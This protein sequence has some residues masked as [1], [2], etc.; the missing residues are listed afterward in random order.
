MNTLAKNHFRLFIWHYIFLILGCFFF[1]STIYGIFIN[2]LPIPFWDQ[3]EAVRFIIKVINGDHSVWFSQHNEH[4][5]FFSRLLFWLDYIYWGGLNKFLLAM[6]VFIQLLTLTL[7]FFTLRVFNN[8]RSVSFAVVGIGFGLLFSWAQFEN[9]IWGFQSQ[10]FA[11]Y[12][13]ALLSL[14]SIVYHHKLDGQGR[15]YYSWLLF[16]ISILSAVLSSLT[17]AN[18]LLIFP[19]LLALSLFIKMSFYKI[20]AISASGLITW[21]LYFSNYT[22]PSQHAHVTESIIN[23]PLQVMIYSFTY[24]GAPIAYFGSYSNKLYLPILAGFILVLGLLFFAFDII[25]KKQYNPIILIFFFFISFI[26]GTAIITAAGRINFGVETALSSR[27][28]TPALLAWFSILIMWYIKIVDF[29]NDRLHFN[30]CLHLILSITILFYL[31]P[32][33]FKAMTPDHSRLFNREIA[34]LALTMDVRDEEYIIHLHPKLEV[35]AN[36]VKQAREL[37][38]G[39]FNLDWYKRV[40]YSGYEYIELQDNYTSCKGNIDLIEYIEEDE[41]LR[42]KGWVLEKNKYQVP[43]QLIVVIPDGKVIGYGLSGQ[44]RL[45]VA[46]VFD[47]APKTSGWIAY[48]KYLDWDRAYIYAFTENGLC[49]L[50]GV[51]ERVEA[52]QSIKSLSLSNEFIGIPKN[53]FLKVKK[54][55]WLEDALPLEVDQHELI[56]DMQVFSSWINSD[57]AIGI[58]SFEL[59]LGGEQLHLPYLTGPVADNQKIYIYK[60]VNNE[61]KLIFKR[62]L[63]PSIHKWSYLII[64]LDISEDAVIRVDFMDDGDTWG[65]WSAIAI[66]TQ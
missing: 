9:W 44:P 19:L 64:D 48:V 25:R 47:G 61:Y 65:E 30:K 66:S 22:N 2:Y 41:A 36:I 4:R 46:D 37:E 16:G 63:P 18:G 24:L 14:F 50:P 28:C 1:F 57:E 62:V 17:M 11:V 29:K 7:I 32:Y 51:V 23:H 39:V 34:M 5:I 33:Q 6:N 8:N 53:S 43:K 27:Y 35:V 52:K 40:Q 38:I 3:W 10:F 31:I 26:L 60:K 42:I 54:N 20:M 55:D 56:K 13:F 45:D 49:K 21:L 58:L 12:T 15:V 59:V